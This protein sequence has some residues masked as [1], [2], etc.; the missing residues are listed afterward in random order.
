MT[1]AVTLANMPSSASDVAVNLIDQ[2]KLLARKTEQTALGLVTEFVYSAGDPN[3]PTVVSA[4]YNVN[5]KT[6][7]IRHSLTLTT[8]QTVTVDSVVTEVAP[9]SITLMWDTP[10]VYEDSAAILAAIGSVYSLAFDSLV[11][12]VPQ[13]GVVDA[14]NRGL[15]Q[16]LFE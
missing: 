3:T 12:K 13:T 8:V 15:T 5:A 1:T 6:G 2:T 14:F 4:L 7:V 9:L 16:K 10:G 11:S